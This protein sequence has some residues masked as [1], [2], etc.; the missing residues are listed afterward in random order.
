MHRKKE[1]EGGEA[2]AERANE[3]AS[4]QAR[5]LASKRSM[6]SRRQYPSSTNRSAP[7]ICSEIRSRGDD[8]W[9]RCRRNRIVY[10][11]NALDRSESSSISSENHDFQMISMIR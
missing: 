4:K 6:M 8:F 10:D 2:D 7:K 5:Q 11:E 9:I 1:R 3:R